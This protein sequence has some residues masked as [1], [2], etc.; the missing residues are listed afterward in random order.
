MA[1]YTI[2]VPL[3]FQDNLL[4]ITDPLS[5]NVWI[6]FLICIPIYVGSI[7]SMNYLYSGSTNWESA[8][9]F[10]VR[11][12]L[13][14]RNW[15]NKLPSKY[16]YQK[17]MILIWGLMMVVLISA[18]KGNLLAII[19]KPTMT[20]PFINAEDMVEQNEIKWKVPSG[21]FSSYAKSKSPG[22]TLRKI[23]D[24]AITSSTSSAMSMDT[25]ESVAKKS[26]NIAI[27][28]DI[29]SATS[30]MAKYF[31]K[32]GTCNYY[33]TQDKILATDNALAFPVCKMI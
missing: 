3:R 10:V 24:R 5:F 23:I 19:T 12:A 30:V 27:I 18:Y 29:S 20:T 6:C 7:I 25:C 33:L 15:Q 4:S 26:A 22:T 21:L 11:A 16:L 14:E 31:S 9:S 32:T 13:S 2:I 8:V 17:L 28:C 1:Y